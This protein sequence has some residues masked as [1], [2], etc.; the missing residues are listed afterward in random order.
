MTAGS[1]GQN[2]LVRR[3]GKVA[4]PKRDLAIMAKATGESEKREV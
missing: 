3:G 2:L 4:V 1:N